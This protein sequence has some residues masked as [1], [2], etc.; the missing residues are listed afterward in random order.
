MDKNTR[1]FLVTA[2]HVL[3]EAQPTNDWTVWPAALWI[4]RPDRYVPVQLFDEAGPGR[5]PRFIHAAREGGFLQDFLA[6]ELDRRQLAPGQVLDCFLTV[7]AERVRLAS[8]GEIVTGY[9]YPDL[10][11]RWPASEADKF[12]GLFSGYGGLLAEADAAVLKGHSGGP[13]FLADGAWLG[14]TIGWDERPDG[15]KSATI[16]PASWIL[17]QL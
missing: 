12:T 17:A 9:G 10:G 6:I 2:A 15:P 16:V 8:P 13:V 1:L 3:V 14:M 11:E 5:T 7:P 4:F